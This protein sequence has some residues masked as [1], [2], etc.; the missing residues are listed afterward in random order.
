MKF[1]SV[2]LVVTACCGSAI[3]QTLPPGHPAV[4]MKKQG[5]G[6]PEA[7]LPQKGKVLSAIDVP[8]YTYIEVEQNKKPLWIAA[9]TISVKKGDVIRFSDGM[10]MTDFFSK[11]LKR[12]FPRISFVDQVVISK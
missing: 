7:Q 11:T 9:P 5:A 6:A 3:A 4:E 8:Q 12:S 10:V 2:L 1:Q